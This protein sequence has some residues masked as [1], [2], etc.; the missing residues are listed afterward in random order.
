MPTTAEAL[1]VVSKP[2]VLISGGIGGLT[3][4]LLLDKVNIP[5][6]VLKRA[7]EVNHWFMLLTETPPFWS[8]GYFE[9]IISRPE[10]YDL[11]FNS[12]PRERI[13]LGKRILS[14]IQNEDSVM[15]R[16]SDNTSYHGDILVGVDGAT[17]P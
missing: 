13:L 11:L 7:K 4:A 12:V 9:H 16:C 10:L 6:L 17:L 8:V 3:L 2:S 14:S 15:V 5:F 1:E